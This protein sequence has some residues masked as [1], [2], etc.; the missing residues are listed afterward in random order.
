[1][2]DVRCTMY[3]CDYSARCAGR[4]R[5]KRRLCTMYDVRCTIWEIRRAK[6]AELRGASGGGWWVKQSGGRRQTESAHVRCTMYNTHDGPKQ[7]LM[8]DVRRRQTES[9]HVRWT[10]YDVRLRLWRAKGA[11]YAERKR[12]GWGNHGR[13][14]VR[15]GRKFCGAVSPAL[16]RH[17]RCQAPPAAL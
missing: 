2:Y 3:D 11:G 4:W 6:L 1:M 9:A 14:L 17:R 10:M 13:S 5:R 8:Y 16:L 12:R 7:L 15:K